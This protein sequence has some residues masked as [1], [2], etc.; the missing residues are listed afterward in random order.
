MFASA[1]VCESPCIRAARVLSMK[2]WTEESRPSSISNAL[3]V[4]G[5]DIAIRVGL[6]KARWGLKDMNYTRGPQWA[7]RAYMTLSDRI[8]I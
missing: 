6:G 4:G 2:S 8:H 5:S 7:Q 1:G 3:M